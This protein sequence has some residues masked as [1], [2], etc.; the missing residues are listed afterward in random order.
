M[1]QSTLKSPDHRS[2]NGMPSRT[3]QVGLIILLG[4]LIIYV[5]A[6]VGW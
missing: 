2:S 1:N 6:R 5:I 3:Q 4:A